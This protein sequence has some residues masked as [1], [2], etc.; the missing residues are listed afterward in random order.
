MKIRLT[1]VQ[2]LNIDKENDT[3]LELPEGATVSE[4]YDRLDIPADRQRFVRAVVNG[5]ERR[6]TYELEDEDNLHLFIHIRS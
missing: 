4:V 3:L 6:P 5:T 1:Y 2:A